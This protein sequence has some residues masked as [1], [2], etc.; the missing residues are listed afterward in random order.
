MACAQVRNEEARRRTKIARELAY[1]A[2]ECC[3]GLGMS[4]EWESENENWGCKRVSLLS[5][6]GSAVMVWAC[7][8]VEEMQRRTEACKRASLSSREKCVKMDWT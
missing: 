2:G 8:R 7:V 6:E 3:D 1:R 5:R 4:K